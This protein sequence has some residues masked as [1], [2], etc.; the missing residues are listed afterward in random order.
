MG[1]LPHE[2]W[3]V[4]EKR[5][6]WWQEYLV[7]DLENCLGEQW[8]WGQQSGGWRKGERAGCSSGYRRWW[9]ALPEQRQGW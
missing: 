8:G 5:G 4:R 2:D 1:C 6:N 3:Q 7:G 9:T